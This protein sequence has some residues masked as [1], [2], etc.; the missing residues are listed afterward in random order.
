MHSIC[1]MKYL[2]ITLYIVAFFCLNLSA[3]TPVVNR[4]GVIMTFENDSVNIAFN[5]K[6]FITDDSCA[7]IIRLGHYNMPERKFNGRFTDVS[8]LNPEKIIGAGTYDKNG[9]KEGEFVSYYL[10]GNLQAKGAFRNNMFNGKWDF[11]YSSGKPN[12]SFIANG[13]EI[14]ILNTWNEEGK[15]L[16]D[17]GYGDYESIVEGGLVWKGKLVGGTPDGKWVLHSMSRSEDVLVT[18]WFKLGEFQKG[19]NKVGDYEDAS[20]IVLVSTDMLPLIKAENLWVSNEPCYAAQKKNVINARYSKGADQFGEEI[21]DRLAPV[22]ETMNV[23]FNEPLEI[24]GKI[25]ETG[26]ISFGAPKGDS[27]LTAPLISALQNLPFL[28][29]ARA[30]GK[31]TQQDM[32]II[33]K[34][35]SSVYSFSYR[36]LPI[37]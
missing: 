18:E 35:N 29:P 15:K 20:H 31:V 16:V 12:I 36:I 23:S 4:E 37:K 17:N 19:H 21:R 6:Y 9:M 25:L 2:F 33:I 1:E 27:K 14:K 34:V 13:S 24:L 10:N 3:Q 8:K 7:D 30:D 28:E 22:L 5:E 26:R 32:I 11:Y